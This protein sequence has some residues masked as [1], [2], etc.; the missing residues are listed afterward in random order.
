M[1]QVAKVIPVADSRY[2]KKRVMPIL[3]SQGLVKKEWHTAE[4]GTL[5]FK[6]GK[7]D[8][9]HC[10]FAL[11][12]EGTAKS[13]WERIMADGAGSREWREMGAE[14]RAEQRQAAEEEKEARHA[15]GEPRTE[16]EIWA[17]KDR[18]K[19]RTTNLER[20]HLNSRRRKARDV[21]EELAATVA[22]ERLAAR[23][24]AE[25]ALRK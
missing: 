23:Q 2:L 14:V 13:R 17:W 3:E 16:R 6:A 10:L 21:K 8:R 11:R 9:K 24:A 18:P 1:H 25:E 22:A 4:P 12:E 19:G 5:M 7:E 20:V 15:A